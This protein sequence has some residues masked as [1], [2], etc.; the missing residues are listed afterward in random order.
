MGRRGPE[1]GMARAE[2]ATSLKV[3]VLLDYTKVYISCGPCLSVDDWQIIRETNLFR[4][5]QIP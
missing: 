2:R 4:A 1:V 3:A 5:Q